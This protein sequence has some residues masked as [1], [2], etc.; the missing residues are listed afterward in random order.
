M[1][2]FISIFL[3]KA[4]ICW[5]RIIYGFHQI[6]HWAEMIP[7]NSKERNRHRNAES[8]VVFGGECCWNKSWN[9]K[10]RRK[11]MFGRSQSDCEEEITSVNNYESVLVSFRWPLLTIVRWTKL[12]ILFVRCDTCVIG[13]CKMSE[14]TEFQRFNDSTIKFMSSKHTRVTEW[15]S[16]FTWKMFL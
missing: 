10:T 9:R 6:D 3:I 15:A 4:L 13:A 7:F 2:I 14:M 1:L 12:C 16:H 8:N 11:G 5:I